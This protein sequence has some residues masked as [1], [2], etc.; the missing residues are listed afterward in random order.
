MK[1]PEPIDFPDYLEAYK[2]KVM[3]LE[4]ENISLRL[5]VKKLTDYAESLQYKIVQQQAS[6]AIDDNVT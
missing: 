4:H 5:K 3:E 6:E 2:A 1:G